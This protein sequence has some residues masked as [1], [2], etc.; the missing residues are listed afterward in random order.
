V[1]MT[2]DSAIILNRGRIICADKV[3]RLTR[4]D[5]VRAEIRAPREEVQAALRALP[6]VKNVT[7]TADGDYW[8]CQV[9]AGGSDVREKIFELA[10]QRH[11]TL[12]ELSHERLSMEDI[13]VKAV[14]R[15]V[16]E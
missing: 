6:D 2:C 10:A 13:F 16:E 12:R 14:T 15:D 8:Q 4:R 7:V 5:L 9:E 1:E 11:W 3:A